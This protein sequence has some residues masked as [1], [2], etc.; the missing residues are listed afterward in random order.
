MRPVGHAALPSDPPP[1][2]HPMDPRRGEPLSPRFAAVLCSR[3]E[4]PPMT[5]PAIVGLSVSGGYV[6]AATTDDPLFDTHLGDWSDLQRNL[7]GWG[8]VC[9]A[10]PATVEGLIAKVRRA[11]S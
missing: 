1:V 10:H 6:L 9:G 7:R 4:L 3:R 8:R 5:R 11:A 2:T